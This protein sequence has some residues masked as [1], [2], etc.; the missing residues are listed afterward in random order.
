MGLDL[1]AAE[2]RSERFLARLA[3]KQEGSVSLAGQISAADVPD[4]IA[5]IRRLSGRDDVE[6][7]AADRFHDRIERECV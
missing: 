6:E 2:R 1:E 7:T 5:E 4:L 3:G